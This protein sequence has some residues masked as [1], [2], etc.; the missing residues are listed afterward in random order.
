MPIVSWLVLGLIA[1]FIGSKIVHRGGN[2][3]GD[4]IVGMI[5]AFVG[6]YLFRLF[7]MRGVSGL[8]L[9]SIGVAI[10]GSVVTLT[11]YYALRRR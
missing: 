4:V 5:G 1:G 7:G 9:W 8:N 10:V 3:V 2:L 11:V 6:G